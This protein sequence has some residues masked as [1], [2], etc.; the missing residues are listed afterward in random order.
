MTDRYDIWETEERLWTGGVEVYRTHMAPGCLMAFPGIG[1][2]QGEAIIAS[3]QDAPRW[4]EVS[5]EGSHKAESDE[6]IV[7]GYTATGQRDD[8]PAYRAVCTS[9]WCLMTEGWRLVQH[10]QSPLD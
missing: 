8:Q 5:F 6:V 9:T 7:L 4:R 3:L 10:H 1:L 2:I